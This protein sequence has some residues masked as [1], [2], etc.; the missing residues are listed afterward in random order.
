MRGS[1]LLAVVA[2]IAAVCA[3]LAQVESDQ[4]WS[5]LKRL[6]Y[7]G[8]ANETPLVNDC[9]DP[10][11]PVS[12]PGLSI[13]TAE[14]CQARNWTLWPSG[15]RR[16]VFD[17][18]F[19]D[20]EMDLVEARI[21]ELEH[22]VDVF[23]VAEASKTH[24]GRSKPSYLKE[25]WKTRLSRFVHKVVHVWV[26]LPFNCTIWPWVCERYQRERMLDGFLEAGG[27]D[28]D[29]VVTSD[30]DEIP[31]ASIVSELRAC[32]FEAGR[33]RPAL[34]RLQGDHFWY[35]AHCKRMDKQWTLGPIAAS[36]RSMRRWGPGQLR[37]PDF[38]YGG[39]GLG[40]KGAQ[41]TSGNAVYRP[42]RDSNAWE[43]Q[44]LLSELHSRDAAAA[45]PPE[46]RAVHER[47]LRSHYLAGTLT[48]RH[49]MPVSTLNIEKLVE[50]EVVDVQILP[51]SSWH[52][53]YFMTPEQ[54]VIKYRSAVVGARGIDDFEQRPPEWHYRMA[55]DCASP[56][57]ATWK[58]TY[59]P[60]ITEAE[61]PRFVL[62]NRCR[63]RSFFRYARHAN[64]LG[65]PL[66]DNDYWHVPGPRCVTSTT[67]RMRT[68]TA[69]V[70]CATSCGRCGGGGCSRRPGGRLSCCGP[71]IYR[72]NRT[73][74]SPEDTVVRRSH[75][76]L[77]PR[78]SL[79]SRHITRRLRSGG[80]LC[81]C[82]TVQLLRTRNRGI[83]YVHGTRHK[84]F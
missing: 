45:V 44:A 46:K 41:A 29:V 48:T 35:S 81:T 39:Q 21:A 3:S 64:T 43:W 7:P 75:P 14:M 4:V 18:F 11:V 76:M 17:L 30:L 56:Q 42:G 37:C 34:L 54:I 19:F 55:M 65:T 70:C 16:R 79:P 59:V 20:H 49:F 22:D 68:V 77:R 67:A 73:C 13:V 27:A 71:P 9:M 60:N 50:G 40:G 24:Q 47:A 62:L 63:M 15:R 28:N 61:V 51:K 33:T 26:D 80:V 58:W 32:D 23:V 72:F 8:D 53:S 66:V 10:I 12:T 2:V 74:T 5:K 84:F 38:V 52:Y 25:A 31:R 69:T 36:G 82:S 83:L 1:A 78:V 6:P 57:H